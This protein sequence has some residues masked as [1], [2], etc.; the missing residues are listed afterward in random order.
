M[1]SKQ[2][3][4]MRAAFNMTKQRC[5]NKKC[6]DYPYYGGRGITICDRWL[7]SFDNLLSDMGLRPDG[8]TLE[9]VDNSKGYSKE[10]CIWASRAA[11]SVNTRSVRKITWQGETLSVADWERRFGWKGG[12]L[13]ARFNALGYTV[14]E[15]MTKPVKC[16]G[17]LL[18]KVYRR[19]LQA[20]EVK[21]AKRE[22]AFGASYQAVAV[23][24]GVAPG[25]LTKLIRE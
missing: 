25:T 24:Y 9:R 8:M 1:R 16:G 5:Y 6:R 19:T 20:E 13:K 2:E 18:G 21:L 14:E 10:N 11:Q 17:V 15:A 22:I 12:T 4:A 23:R 7:A 3:Q